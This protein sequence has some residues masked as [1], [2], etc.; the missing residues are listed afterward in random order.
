[1]GKPKRWTDERIKVAKLPSRIADRRI[2]I[3]PGLYLRIRLTGAGSLSKHWEY[4][5]QVGGSRRRLSLGEYPAMP[6]AGAR[7][8]LLQHQAAYDKAKRGD[9]DHPVIAARA[10]R[11]ATLEQ[12][13]VEQTFDG[14]VADKRLGSRRKRGEP[15]RERT[16]KILAEN[17]DADVRPKIGDAKVATLTADLLREC[18]DA[19]RR[20][21]SPGA[22]AHVYRTLR[23]LVTFAIKRGYIT[24]ADPMRGIDNPRP[25]RPQPPN[26]ANDGEIVGLLRALESSKLWEST[27]LAIEFQ[28]FTGAR[29]GEVRLAEWSEFKMDRAT[30]NIP[31]ER[32][33]SGR[34]FKVHLSEAA[35]ALLKQAR[36]LRDPGKDKTGNLVFPGANGG[37]ME[38]MAVARALSR[39]AERTKEAGGKKLRPHDLRRTFRTL[40][41]RIGVAP[42]V[43]E[44]CLGHVERETMRRVYDGHDYS[45]ECA[46]AWDRAGA[47]IA[48]LQAGGAPGDPDFTGGRR[49]VRQR[50][51]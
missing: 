36:A 4:R 20:R 16:I 34:P 24:G 50:R 48:A 12:P 41:S 22:A 49:D 1:M 27:R 30:W 23:G 25:Y 44:L 15:V 38:K 8:A 35:L 9:G 47:H 11:K 7:A 17:F 51:A 10:A 39:I 21:G 46:D 5:A 26:A 6:L 42:H 29:P 31:A 37:T 13:T 40:L 3:E 18:I 43:A 28:L 19:P 14:W 32:F 33:K 2:A 45:R